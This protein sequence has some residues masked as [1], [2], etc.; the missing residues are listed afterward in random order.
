MLNVKQWLM[1]LSEVS[2]NAVGEPGNRGSGADESSGTP[3]FENASLTQGCA[4]PDGSLTRD[5]LLSTLTD[6]QANFVL[7]KIPGF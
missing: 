2:G 1:H 7:S 5:S 3:S 4:F 6:E